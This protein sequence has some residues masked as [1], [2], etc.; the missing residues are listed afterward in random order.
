MHAARGR[1]LWEAL[2]PHRGGEKCVHPEPGAQLLL[3]QDRARRLPSDSPL[4]GVQHD[5]G[6]GQGEGG[7]AA[8]E[9]EYGQV[10]VP[11]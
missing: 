10:R 1:R 6:D 2:S 5:E 8:A 4:R 9:G 3:P 11:H 7:H